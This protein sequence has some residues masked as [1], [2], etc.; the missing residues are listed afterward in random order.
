M[1]STFK[2]GLTLASEIDSFSFTLLLSFF[3]EVFG[4]LPVGLTHHFAGFM[5]PSQTTQRSG[6][7]AMVIQF[8]N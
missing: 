1:V 7:P 3:S 5:T 4:A 6:R 8:Y 2:S